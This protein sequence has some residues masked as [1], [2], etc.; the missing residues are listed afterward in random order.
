MRTEGTHQQRLTR[1][2]TRLIS[3]IALAAAGE[4]DLEKILGQALRRLGKHVPFTGGSIALVEGDELVI[5]AAVGLFAEQAIRQRLPK[6][7]GESWRVVSSKEP[8]LLNDVP[9][10]EHVS[11]SGDE[12]RTIRSWLAVPLVRRG[13]GIG[14]LEVDSVVASAFEEADLALVRTVAAVLAGPVELA[15]RYAAEVR[16]L[17]EARDAQRRLAILNEALKARAKQQAAV[18]QLGQAALEASELHRLLKRAV[19]LVARTLGV[20]YAAVFQYLTREQT[21]RPAAGIG[22]GRSGLAQ[23]RL[24][25]GHGS[26]AGYTLLRGAPVFVP[27]VTAEKR[28]TV[29]PEVLEHTIVSSLSVPIQGTPDPYGV[30]VTYSHV[31]RRFTSDDI[32]FVVAIANILASAVERVR[33]EETERKVGELRDAFLGVISHEL[34]TPITTIYG[35]AKI[36]RNSGRRLPEATR[37][38]AIADIEAEAERLYRLVEDLLVLSRSE[39]GRLEV[40]D[41][42]VLLHHLL[43][44]VVH[45]ERQRR[46]GLQLEL[47]MPRRLPAACGEETYI[48]Q[49]VRNLIANAAKYGPPDATIELVAEQQEGEVIVRVL[50]RGPGISPDEAESMFELFYRSKRMAAHVGGAGIGLFVC[51]QLVEAMGGRI[52]ARVRP[53]GGADFGFT[54]PMYAL[55]DELEEEVEPDAL[56]AFG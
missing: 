40:G 27:D 53:E 44:R 16:A 52:W 14:L 19:D 50:D 56:R 10:E 48:E 37:S 46:P 22:F 26:Q 35:S 1:I 20:R 6:G 29:E 41:E 7:K 18:A 28:F 23:V 30:L 8:S 45:S 36:L 49:V 34:R 47:L 42:P 43:P 38:E 39:G 5:R 54:L 33:V 4:H 9:A 24:R 32:N 21:L 25:A 2:R 15:S 51:R 12:T 17:E 3:E 13:Q 31:R 55:P 11:L